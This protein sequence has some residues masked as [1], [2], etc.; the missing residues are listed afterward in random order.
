MRCR[1]D[2][3]GSG[4]GL[5][6][7]NGTSPWCFNADLTCDLLSSI[8]SSDSV[9]VGDCTRVLGPGTDVSGK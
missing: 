4:S 9:V 2:G 8:F 1:N 6:D 3:A 7:T 5:A